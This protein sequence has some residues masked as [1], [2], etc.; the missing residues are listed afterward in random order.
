LP[1]FRVKL[2][3]HVQW[4]EVKPS[5]ADESLLW[6]F[7]QDSGS[8][9]TPLTTILQGT[10]LHEIPDPDDVAA[11]IHGP[12]RDDFLILGDNFYQF[13]VC[14]GCNAVGFQYSGLAERIE[15]GCSFSGGRCYTNDAPRILQA[16]AAA[17]AARFEHG[18][19]G[20]GG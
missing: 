5:G 9:G 13:C 4:A 17:R 18:E 7:I 2:T 12:N 6:Q 15:C 16:Y 1:D 11:G 20:D 19:Y 3:N 10:V 8:D 14:L